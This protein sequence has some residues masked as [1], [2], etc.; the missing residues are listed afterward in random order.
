MIFDWV[1]VYIS[2]WNMDMKCI[3]VSNTAAL[4]F[5]LSRFVVFMCMS[6]E[7]ISLFEHGYEVH[8]ISLAFYLILLSDR[9]KVY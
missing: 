6:W 7:S 2:I 4:T 5:F 9:V 8:S 3:H 1:F